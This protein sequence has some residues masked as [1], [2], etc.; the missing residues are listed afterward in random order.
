MRTICVWFPD[1]PLAGMPEDVC[2]FVYEEGRAAGGETERIA[3]ANRLARQAGVTIGMGR[4]ASEALCPIATSKARDL[5]EETR[6]FEP[7]VA[8]L[9]DLVPR[10]EV[11][12]PGLV[13]IA[14]EGSLRFYGGEDILLDK[15]IGTAGPGARVGLADGP[16]AAYW[17]ARTAVNE[18][19]VVENTMEFLSRLDISVIDREE[20]IDTFRWL[21]LT[22]LGALGELPRA[23]IASRFGDEGLRAHRLATGE[24][25]PVNPRPIP[26]HLA[27]EAHYDDPL[28][29]LDQVAF[30]A[31]ALSARLMND[32]RREGIAPHR[33]E[34]EAESARGQVRRRV[35]RSADP[36]LE[37]SLVERVWWQLRAWV[38]GEGVEGGLVRLRLDPSDLSGRGRQLAL[39]E[40]SEMGWETYDAN[41]PEAERALHRVQSLVGPDEVLQGER[42]G[43]RMPGEQ[44]L[45]FRFGEEPTPAERDPLAPWP[46]A[47]PGPAPALVPPE[48]R[49]I[50]I[51]WEGGMPHR[52]R[53]GARWEQVV[54]WAGP[55]RL[56]GRWWKGEEA[57]DRYQ[58][59][60]SAGAF[61]VIVRGERTFLAGIYD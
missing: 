57:A 60:T 39:L 15:V 26:P 31:R 41:R 29:S 52:V 58:I 53:L 54:N 28:E 22:T 12:E 9:E 51:E 61:L 48:P 10:I 3:A 36:F 34:I 55:W 14:F 40:Q 11:V 42:Q 5:G 7:V 13:L 59:V 16:F 27:V 33:V 30:S 1:W 32:L 18:P 24:D 17:A 45:W 8:S 23:A 35:W 6:R 43:G 37:Y 25:R 47:T 49:P 56:L 2:G 21:G 19:N 46:G 38:E 44:V 50:D 4:R 20:M